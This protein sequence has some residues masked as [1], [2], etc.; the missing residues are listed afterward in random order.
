MKVMRKFVVLAFHI[1]GLSC[2]V[3][4]ALLAMWSFGSIMFFG[5]VWAVEPNLPILYTEFGLA[6]FS[7][8]YAVWTLYRWIKEKALPLFH[9]GEGV[10]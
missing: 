8:A 3:A 1:V 5:Y 6:V 2:L 9:V 4:A 7:G 10:A